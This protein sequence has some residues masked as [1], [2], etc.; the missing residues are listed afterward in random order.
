MEQENAPRAPYKLDNR[1]ENKTSDRCTPSGPARIPTE[2][3]LVIFDFSCTPF[4][5]LAT[6]RD[7]GASIA[8]RRALRTKNALTLVCKFWHKLALPYLYEYIVLDSSRQVTALYLTAH[9][10]N[11]DIAPLIKHL[12]LSLPFPTIEQFPQVTLAQVASI[13][14]TAARLRTLTFGTFFSWKYIF[15]LRDSTFRPLVDALQAIGKRLRTLDYRF[16]TTYRNAHPVRSLE[17]TA[18]LS[19]LVSLT[20][21]IPETWNL[22]GGPNT[23]VVQFLNL[24]HLHLTCVSGSDLRLVTCWRLPRLRALTITG[25]TQ[26][27]LDSEQLVDLLTQHGKSIEYLDVSQEPS[28]HLDRV[29]DIIHLCPRLIHVVLTHVGIPES[30]N[31]AHE[32]DH[33]V[34][35]PSLVHLDIWIE[36]VDGVLRSPFRS[37]KS[38]V[39]RNAR[40]LDYDL[41]LEFRH[42]PRL[43]GPAKVDIPGG[44]ITYSLPMLD[45]VETCDQVVLHGRKP[46]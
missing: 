41:F 20:L 40:V 45:I 31:L 13:L 27:V 37:A 21:P 28:A 1:L 3:I 34:T 33:N 32:P 22:D 17:L 11:P 25:G 16:C 26:Y 24:E 14:N 23:P 10:R 6:E 35:H 44:I 8:W 15:D 29:L 36:K 2:L 7:R 46:L 5:F 12:H 38:S 19:E 43:I 30:R 42:L 18:S 4:Q 39:L 9:E